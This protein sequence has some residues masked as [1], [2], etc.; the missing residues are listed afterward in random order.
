MMPDEEVLSDNETTSDEGVTAVTSTEELTSD[1]EEMPGLDVQFVCY[2]AIRGQRVP[3]PEHLDDEVVQAS[4]IRGIRLDYA[5]AISDEVTNV[6]RGVPSFARARNARLIMSNVIPVDM[7][8]E[9]RPYCI[10]YPDFATEETY[11]ALVRRHPQMRYAAGRACAAAGYDALYME[12]DL[13]PDVSIAEE[14]RESENE[15]SRRIFES[16]MSGSV[17]YAVMDDFTRAINTT[18]PHSPAFLNGDTEVRWRLHPRDPAISM[19]VPRFPC[20]EEDMHIDVSPITAPYHIPYLNDNEIRLLYE[21]L[22]QDLPTVKKE[23]LIQMAAFDGNIDRY[24]RLA[25]PARRMRVMELSCVIRGIYHHTM[26][27]RWWGNEIAQNTPRAQVV[28]AVKFE[29]Y[30]IDSDAVGSNL[31]RIKMAISARRIMLNDPREF[32]DNGWPPNVPQPYFIWYPLRP[33][34]EM[35]SLLAKKVPSMAEQAAVA[36]IFCDYESEFKS[37]CPAPN[38]RLWFAASQSKNPLYKDYLE[39]KGAKENID[40][41]AFEMDIWQ[42]AFH[43]RVQYCMEFDLEPTDMVD[44][45]DKNPQ[46]D[47]LFTRLGPYNEGGRP[48]AGKLEFKIWSPFPRFPST[49]N[50]RETTPTPL[51]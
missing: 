9:Q 40:T 26:Y 5:F 39:K 7:T 14:A 35:L 47:S 32:Q 37:I 11:R 16:I 50:T 24:S 21:P 27:A 30:F 45:S 36:A 41:W 49:A 19:S 33:R 17:R 6:A 3:G 34:P 31:D 28:A 10:W 22:P 51:P 13:L 2:P 42:G 8:E 43:D 18:N 25:T 12:L 23:L 1:E 46:Y 20:I 38:I 4:L 48:D 44:F 15:G 29:P